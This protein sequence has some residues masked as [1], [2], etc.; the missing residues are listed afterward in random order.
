MLK[1]VK[2]GNGK[3]GLTARDCSNERRF[4][5]KSKRLWDLPRFAI[6]KYI[7]N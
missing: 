3:F 1:E 7:C 6:G 2:E 4:I 5:C